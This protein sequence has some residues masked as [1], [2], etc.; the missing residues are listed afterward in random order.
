ML[1]LLSLSTLNCGTVYVY[2]NIRIH[3]NAAN[4]S[5]WCRTK[6]KQQSA[7]MIYSFAMA[8]ATVIH[9]EAQRCVCGAYNTHPSIHHLLLSH[10]LHLYSSVCELT[11]SSHRLLVLCFACTMDYVT[12][13]TSKTILITQWHCKL[14]NTISRIT[15]IHSDINNIK[16]MNQT[17][18]YFF[19]R[20][21]Q[22]VLL[23]LL[24][25][26]HVNYLTLCVNLYCEQ[27]FLFCRKQIICCEN[28]ICLCVH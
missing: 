21:S 18:N 5:A 20:F 15:W 11:V 26:N 27:T 7:N 22:S 3:S 14:N 16:W 1:L 2:A 24:H 17:L 12:K 25:T 4:W 8:R 28:K 13:I 19:F 23:F 9:C 10:L 6:H